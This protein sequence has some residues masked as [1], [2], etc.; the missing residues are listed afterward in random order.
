MSAGERPKSLFRM[1][2]ARQGFALAPG[3]YEPDPDRADDAGSPPHT[4]L[5]EKEAGET[6]PPTALIAILLWF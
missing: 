2:S 6:I 4:F 5:E 3:L 1:R